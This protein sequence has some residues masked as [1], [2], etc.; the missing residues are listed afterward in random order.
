M[1]SMDLPVPELVIAFSVIS[2]GL[3]AMLRK[4]LPT[5]LLGLGVAGFGLFHG[6]AYGE[7]IIG[8][9]TS[10]IVAY[11]IGLSLIQYA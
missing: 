2:A 4:E 5:L 6:Y 11:L 9:E 1:I 8:A 7:S 3:L 10:P